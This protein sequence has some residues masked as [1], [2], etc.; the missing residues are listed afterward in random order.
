MNSTERD[1]RSGLARLILIVLGLAALVA[2]ANFVFL[3]PG[4][5]EKGQPPPQ[6]IDQESQ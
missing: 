6:T 5:P 1:T 3:A 4:E 2:V